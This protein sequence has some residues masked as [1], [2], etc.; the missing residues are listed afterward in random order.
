M[1][2]IEYVYFSNCRI[3]GV[4]FGRIVLVWGIVFKYVGKWKD[5]GIVV[6][7]RLVLIVREK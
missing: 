6:E 3:F 1:I 2:N 5:E 4:V 7:E